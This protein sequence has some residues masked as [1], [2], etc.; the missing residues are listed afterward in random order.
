MSATI[1]IPLSDTSNFLDSSDTRFHG[2]GVSAI[3]KR[4]DAFTRLDLPEDFEIGLDP[5]LRVGTR[6]GITS[7]ED[8]L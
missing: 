4:A 5:I 3:V 2:V 7:V 6:V 8:D 1:V